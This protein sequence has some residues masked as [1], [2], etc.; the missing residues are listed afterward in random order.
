MIHFCLA[1]AAYHFSRW[2]PK[3]H[4]LRLYVP[5]LKS[6]P[7]YKTQTTRGSPAPTL[8]HALIPCKSHRS[9]GLL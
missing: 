5:H 4:R 1:H 9:M 6:C 8:L 2:L 7:I 3:H